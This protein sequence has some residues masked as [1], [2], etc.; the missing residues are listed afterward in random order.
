MKPNYTKCFSRLNLL[1]IT[2]PYTS[3]EQRVT[4]K[5]AE[6]VKFFSEDPTT[7]LATEKTVQ[8]NFPDQTGTDTLGNVTWLFKAP[9][10]YSW[11]SFDPAIA[12]ATAIT[13]TSKNIH[14]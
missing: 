13:F 2:L 4:Y 12:T 6:R 8:A 1:R 7:T 9:A 10:G 11:I 3:S 14:F 5:A